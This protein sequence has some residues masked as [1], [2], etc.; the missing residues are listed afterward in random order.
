MRR[1]GSGG[2]RFSFCS[3][4]KSAARIYVKRLRR[5]VKEKSPA[6]RIDAETDFV[7]PNK[8]KAARKC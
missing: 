8:K 2:L 6:N 4:N 1:I 5:L 7:L 3:P